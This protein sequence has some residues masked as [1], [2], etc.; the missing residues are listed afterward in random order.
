LNQDGKSSGLTVPNGKAQEKVILQ[1]LADARLSANDID[2]IEAHGTGTALGD[3]IEIEALGNTYGRSH[4]PASPLLLG[5]VKSNI[6]HLEP[7]A[8]M[9][10]LFKVLQALRHEFLPPNLHFHT[11][12]PYIPWDQI[13]IKVITQLTPWKQTGGKIRRAGISAFGF[14]GTNAHIIV[15]EA[16]AVEVPISPSQQ[17]AHWLLTLS[18]KSPQALQDLASRYVDFLAAD[19]ATL[20][21]IA[22]TCQAGRTHFQY[23]LAAGGETKEEIR[24]KINAYCAGN[25]DEVVS[26]EVKENKK[27]AFL[28]SGQGAQYV[29]MGQELYQEHPV[30]RTAIQR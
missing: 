23:R 4:S 21:D 20:G 14:S 2:Y 10:G 11:P 29:G 7:A 1:A 9:S 18:A 22:Y 15:E 3:P 5:S 12:N 28:F 17:G 6:G 26:G 27:V 30:F 13:P 24:R 25:P 8:G 19:M 16:P